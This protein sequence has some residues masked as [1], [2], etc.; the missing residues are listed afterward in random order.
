LRVI[1]T[2]TIEELFVSV[3]RSTSSVLPVTMMIGA[4]NPV[5]RNSRQT[6]KPFMVGLEIGA[7]DYLTKPFGQRELV[8]RIRVH[9]RRSRGSITSRPNP[10]NLLE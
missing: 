3:T 8:A 5:R 6:S 7:D 4:S 10:H 9:L 1:E 2:L